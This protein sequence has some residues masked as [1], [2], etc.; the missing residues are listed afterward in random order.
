MPSRNQ[1][2]VATGV[3]YYH[4]NNEAVFFE[5]LA[6][7]ACVERFE[8]EGHD[9]STCASW[10]GSAQGQKEHG[11]AALKCIGIAACMAV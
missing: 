10:L 4:Q 3:T 8:G 9:R 11:F 5:W 7:V 6:R 2:L 1:A